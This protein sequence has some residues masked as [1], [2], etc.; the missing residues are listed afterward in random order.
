MIPIE[1][2]TVEY[3]CS[4]GIDAYGDVPADR[5]AE[6]VTVERTGGGVDSLADLDSPVLTVQAWSPTR[7]SAEA[8]MCRA[9]NALLDMPDS[10]AAVT[11]S[12]VTGMYNFPAVEERS[13]R[14]QAVVALRCYL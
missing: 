7:V 13:A 14:Y 9:C 5:P 3:L 11:D 2:V 6:F 10:V 4:V 1:S 12:E 8:L